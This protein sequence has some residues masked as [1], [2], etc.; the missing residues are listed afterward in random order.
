MSSHPPKFT[1][2]HGI[3]KSPY[4][5]YWAGPD[6]GRRTAERRPTLLCGSAG[7]GKTVLAMEFLVRGATEFNEPGVFMAFEEIR[8]G[9]E[10]ECRV[11]GLWSARSLGAQEDPARLFRVE[12]N[13]IEETG[14]YD[15]EGLFIR[16]EN[17]ID[18]I[19]A[20]RVVLDTIEALFSGFANAN[21]LRAELR[22]LFSW[23][24]TKGVTAVITAETGDGKLT[25][26]GME[27]YVADCVIVLDHR[28]EDQIVDPA[29]ARDQVSGHDARNKRV[30]VPDRRPA[31]R[32]FR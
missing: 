27:D 7:C 29:A 17:A 3:A 19:G 9:I 26:H 25:R 18:T 13:E 21:I 11:H 1:P 20:K 4:G 15:L 5:Y 22:R 14:D 16:L 28:V 30:S 24:K 2:R 23:L 32:Y 6:H 10:P 8:Q 12:R 31:C